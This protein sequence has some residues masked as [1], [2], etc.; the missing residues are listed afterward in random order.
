MKVVTGEKERRNISAPCSGAPNFESRRVDRRSNE[1]GL[2]LKASNK[3]LEFSSVK[4]GLQFS[5]F[6]RD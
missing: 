2:V 3:T 4:P 6:R 1:P 5:Y